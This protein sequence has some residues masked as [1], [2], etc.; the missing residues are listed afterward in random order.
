MDESQ[1]IPAFEALTDATRLSILRFL[2]TRGPNGATA[3]EIG[4]SVG[5]QS[6]RAAFH[7]AKLRQSGLVHAE[8]VSRNVIYR[9]DFEKLGALIDYLIEDCCAGS[10]ALKTC[11]RSLAP[12]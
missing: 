6:S 4:L 12:S 1:A 11:C 7:L 5:A 3:G 10:T 2:V 8:K 9:I